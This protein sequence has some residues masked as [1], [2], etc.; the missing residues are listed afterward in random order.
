MMF[1]IGLA[2]VNLL[3]LGIYTRADVPDIGPPP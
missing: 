2:Y 1:L 3:A